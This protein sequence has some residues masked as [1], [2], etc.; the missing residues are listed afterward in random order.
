M[1]RSTNNKHHFEISVQ[2]LLLL[3]TT[4]PGGGG[5]PPR[6]IQTQSRPPASQTG[7]CSSILISSQR[8][9]MK[10]AGLGGGCFQ[11]RREDAI[12]K[13]DADVLASEAVDVFLRDRQSERP[14]PAHFP[15]LLLTPPLPA[16][17]KLTKRARLRCSS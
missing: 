8:I 1:E 16:A 5:G 2:R 3:S 11:R 9:A 13:R 14:R 12:S 15:R 4:W 10:R 17:E 6:R 7:V